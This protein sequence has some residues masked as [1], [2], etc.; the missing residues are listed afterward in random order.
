MSARTSTLLVC[1]ITFSVGCSSRGS[2]AA[3]AQRSAAP[4]Q[5][6]AAPSATVAPKAACTPQRFRVDAV[7][8][9]ARHPCRAWVEKTYRRAVYHMGGASGVLWTQRTPRRTGLLVTAAHAGWPGFRDGDQVGRPLE[10]FRST[11]CSARAR[12]SDVAGGAPQRVAHHTFLLV[13]P[14]VSASEIANDGAPTRKDWMLEVVDGQVHELHD[15]ELGQLR[16]PYL[17]SGEAGAPL[18][19]DDASRASSDSPTFASARADSL[20]LLLGYPQLGAPEA[21]PVLHDELRQPTLLLG[22]LE[23]DGP[24]P[25]DA[26]VERRLL[27]PAPAIALGASRRSS[28]V[29]PREPSARQ[30]PPSARPRPGACQRLRHS[31]HEPARYARWRPPTAAMASLGKTR[32]DDDSPSHT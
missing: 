27:R 17:C 16:E 19:L 21:D 9:D 1:A 32:I 10:H 26:A 11:M 15:L 29:A 24:V 23:E 13:C 2:E 20:V 3:P 8:R 25:L 18:E 6:S 28:D 14:D 5:E 12:F 7:L 31:F 22:L 30:A 4:A